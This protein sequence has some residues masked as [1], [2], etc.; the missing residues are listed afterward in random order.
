[1]RV[2]SYGFDGDLSTSIKTGNPRFFQAWCQIKSELLQMKLYRW[3]FLPGGHPDAH[4]ALTMD[5]YVMATFGPGG[6]VRL[7]RAPPGS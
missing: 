1:M 4:E 2:T 6:G 7:F 5:D 3:P